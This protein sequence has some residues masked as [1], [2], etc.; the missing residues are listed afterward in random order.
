[1]RE[2]EEMKSHDTAWKLVEEWAKDKERPL[3]E[4]DIKNL[5]EVILVRPFWKEAITPD[6]QQTRR[7]IKIGAY[8][9]YPN[10]VRLANGEMFE[11]ASPVETP[12][13]MQ[14]LIDWYRAEESSLHWVTL[15]AMLHYKFVRIHPFDDGN[16]RMARLLMNYVLLRNT[17]P[18]VIIKSEQKQAY[19]R[20]LHI[21]DTGDF[22]PFIIY[23]AEQLE[24][25]L[26]ISIKAAKGES[27][28]E[29]EDWQK[30]LHLL[31]N[32]IGTSNEVT[33]KRSAEGYKLA[34]KNIILP[35][36]NSW[37]VNLK[38]FDPLFNRR[39]C[40]I[41]LNN[42]VAQ[43]EGIDLITAIK[44]C[45]DEESIL[46]L[47]LNNKKVT[48]M[49]I[50]V[51]FSDL[52][53]NNLKGSFNGGEVTINFYENALSIATVTEK[54]ISKLYSEVLTDNE[55]KSLTNDLGNWVLNHLEEHINSQNK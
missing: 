16:G 14:E 23:V 27:I 54:T 5:N 55:A 30:K 42:Q 47:P 28:E 33:I 13:L 38:S 17:L 45:F 40:Q 48:N 35:F 11:Y 31:K 10:S 2:Y 7:E 52:R 37:E 43:V 51:D 9:Q 44:K 15:A 20:V 25:S 21:A 34:I 6:G 4:E 18:P 26:H 8:K 50:I 12:S 3:T 32:K 1:M 24:W 22:E 53:T 29:D 41:L 46:L 36:L 39:R 19:L 49:K